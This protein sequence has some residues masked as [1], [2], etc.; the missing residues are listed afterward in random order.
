MPWFN[1]FPIKD[2]QPNKQKRHLPFIH[3]FL[4]TQC[5][6]YLSLFFGSSDHF[7]EGISA[8]GPYTLANWWGLYDGM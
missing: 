1:E 4:I 6:D 8:R 7:I 2:F 3:H 5:C